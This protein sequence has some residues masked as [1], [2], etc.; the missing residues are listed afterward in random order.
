MWLGLAAALNGCE[1]ATPDRVPVQADSAQPAPVETAAADQDAAATSSA[2]T[3]RSEGELLA[4]T[5]FQFQS[6]I[7]LRDASVR[8]MLRLSDAQT[9][10]LADVCDEAQ[11]RSDALRKVSRD[12]LYKRLKDEYL[13]LAERFRARLE[14]TLTE[15]QRDRLWKLVVQQQRGAVALLLPRVPELL[16]MSDEQ[17]RGVEAIVLRNLKASDPKNFTASNLLTLLRTA[18]TARSD[19][20]SVLSAGQRAKWH[21]LLNQ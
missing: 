7:Q 17:V 20:E 18:A 2:E 9:A 4:A 12:E 21:E 19:A 6:L 10:R 5:L 1:A 8:E 3:G 14:A 11:R 16:E 13:P 15:P